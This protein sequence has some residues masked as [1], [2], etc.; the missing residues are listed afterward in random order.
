MFN[1]Y[2]LI[3]LNDDLQQAVEGFF[4]SI[5]QARRAAKENGIQ[6]FHIYEIATPTDYGNYKK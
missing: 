2:I 1:K 4:T 6:V 3:S 5:Q